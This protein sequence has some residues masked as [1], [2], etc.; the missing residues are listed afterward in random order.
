MNTQEILTIIAMASLGLCLVL[1]FSKRLTKN[2]KTKESLTHVCSLLV[3][4]TVALLAVTQ[5]LSEKEN[6]DWEIGSVA[7]SSMPNGER[8]KKGG[9]NASMGVGDS[10][11]KCWASE[12]SDTSSGL[13]C[14]KKTQDTI[15]G[16]KEY[17]RDGQ[18]G[19]RCST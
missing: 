11:C 16:K 6:M 14:T 18:F 1:A 8:A 10:N 3:V 4:I 2:T 17:C 5:F 13:D 15:C 9:K 7:T 19:P 12:S